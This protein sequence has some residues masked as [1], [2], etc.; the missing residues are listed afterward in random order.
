MNIVLVSHGMLC[1]GFMDA[2]RMMVSNP[3]S[4]SS[5]S[6]D[7]HGVDDFRTRLTSE[8]EHDLAKGNTIIMSDLYGGTP[9]NESYALYLQHPGSLRVIAGIN[10]PM[11]IEV[12]VTATDND[13]LDDVVRIALKAGS[14]G[15]VAAELPEETADDA[16]DLF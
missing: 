16:D 13:S 10:F 8:I 5:V 6:L 7:D 9:F 4:I 1:E 15:V 12:V 14:Q 2:L 3:T 11:L